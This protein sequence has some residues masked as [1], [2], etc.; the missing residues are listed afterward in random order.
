MNEGGVGLRDLDLVNGILAEEGLGDF[1]LDLEQDLLRLG[2]SEL[3]RLRRGDGVRDLCRD[4]GGV[5]KCN[6]ISGID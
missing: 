5:L 4:R 2:E 1:D 6:K 3:E